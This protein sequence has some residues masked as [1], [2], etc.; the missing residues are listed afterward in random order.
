MT[1]D[2]PTG[3]TVAP[4]SVNFGQQG[5][6]SLAPVSN[7]NWQYYQVQVTQPS[8]YGRG[9]QA[10]EYRPI[11]RH[12]SVPVT[13]PGLVAHGALVTALTSTDSADP[14]PAYSLPAVG[15]AGSTPPSIGDAA[16]PG[17]LQLV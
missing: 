4:V 10:T 8:T 17:T 7:S 16:F 3:L 2:G 12:V 13:E 6:P 14:T 9:M 15:A 5:N 11:K 1:T